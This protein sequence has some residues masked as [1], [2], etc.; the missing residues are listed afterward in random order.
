M[1]CAMKGG[2]EGMRKI[3][4]NLR[5]RL[6]L[7]VF[8]AVVPIL[9]L[10]WLI[11]IEQRDRAL[12]DAQAEVERVARIAASRE[13]EMVASAQAFLILLANLPDLRN[14]NITG[15]NEMLTKIVDEHYRYYASFWVAD[16]A[17]NVVC[18]P[19][20]KHT[21]HD[22]DTC[23]HYN[24]LLANPG[25]G[26]VISNY[27][28]C[29]HTG[30]SVLSIGLPINNFSNE[31]VLVSSISLDLAWFYDF[32]AEAALPEGAELTVVDSR[33]TILAH[34]PDNDEWRGI[35]VPAES[36]LYE[37]LQSGETLIVGSDIHGTDS[38]IA[39]SPLN[40]TGRK[41]QVALNLPTEL[42]FA[43]A[44]QTLVR[45]L[46]ILCAVLLFASGSMWTASN[47]LVLQPV[48]RLVEATQRVAE[49]DL[50]IRS[51]IS[52][53]QGELGQLARA[54]DSMA[55]DLSNRDQERT[56]HLGELN[57]YARDLEDSNRELTDFASIAAHDLREPLRKI[58]TFN[59]L[60]ETRH[61]PNLGHEGQNYVQRVKHTADRMLNLLDDLRTYSMVS[62]KA[63]PFG[64]V[65]L[66]KIA[67]QVLQNLDL[68]IRDQQ[69]RISVGPL[70]TLEAD[71]IQ[72]TQ[73]LE[74]LVSNALKFHPPGCTPVVRITSPNPSK[75]VNGYCEFQVEDEGVG[76]DERYKDRLFQ[77][78]ER[79]HAR[80]AFEGTGIGLAICRKIVT[81]HGG[82]ISAESSPGQGARFIVRLPTVQ[83]RERAEKHH[84]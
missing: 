65:N 58:I 56:R 10:V 33:G 60:L 30:K 53:E 77:P 14:L 52:Y 66:N 35:S 31:R 59:E 9:L 28:I 12:E 32:A 74:N 19:P 79:L 37:L 4:N 64:S 62:L 2:Q 54:F 67:S 83:P 23:N 81:R 72:M 70:P 22:F 76:F 82:E 47:A 63:Q 34:Y 45:N 75:A 71:E 3:L 46:L 26:F 16:L 38:I 55:A 11:S 50:A 41:V 69:A 15:C 18:S 7:L 5:S 84:V 61:G 8:L 17:G 73:L 21:P 27:H 78:F 25:D 51:E 43:D 49:G 57:D 44:N 13:T 39:L 6:I 68:Q 24:S 80:E 48:N 20:G 29:E 36:A 40:Y 1:G 42:A